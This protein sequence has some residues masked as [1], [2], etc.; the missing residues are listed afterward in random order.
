M[1]NDNHSYYRNR[2]RN[3]LTRGVCRVLIL[4]VLWVELEGCDNKSSVTD[5]DFAGESFTAAIADSSDR[6]GLR[7]PGVDVTQL[8]V[9]CLF[10]KDKTGQVQVKEGPL[11]KLFPFTWQVKGDSMLV[12]M[13]HKTGGLFIQKDPNGYSLSNQNLTIML[14]E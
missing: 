8:Q 13:D 2:F 5:D 3:Q 11:T 14:T 12:T 10:E 9:S 4:G 7:K 1:Y 6:F